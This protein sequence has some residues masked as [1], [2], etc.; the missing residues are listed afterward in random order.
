MPRHISDNASSILTLLNNINELIVKSSDRQSAS[1]VMR[2]LVVYADTKHFSV[3]KEKIENF[4]KIL[5]D[6]KPYTLTSLIKS[7]AEDVMIEDS[8][9]KKK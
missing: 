9:N 7:I 2:A 1:E 8:K 5:L 4:Y 6:S 3:S